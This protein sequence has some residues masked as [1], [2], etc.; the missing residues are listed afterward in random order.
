MMLGGLPDG[1]VPQKDHAIHAVIRSLKL[2]A[3]PL[4]LQEGEAGD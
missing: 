2:S 3:P 1:A 4:I